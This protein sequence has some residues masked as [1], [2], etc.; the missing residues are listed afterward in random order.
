MMWYLGDP[1]YI[2][3]DEDWMEFCD[4]LN[5]NKEI[6]HW[7]GQDIEILSNG[8]D[9]RWEFHGLDTANGR[10]SFGVDAGIFCA[11]DLDKLEGHYKDNPSQCGLLFDKQPDAYVSDGVIWINEIPDDSMSECERCYEYAKHDDI[12]ECDY[13]CCRGC[14]GCNDGDFYLEHRREDE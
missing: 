8:G 2:I 11:I 7:K 3:P 1:C 14:T 9:G 13:G 10:K 6:I 12:L 4:E 5:K